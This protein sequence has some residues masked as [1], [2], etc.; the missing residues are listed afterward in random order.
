M[1]EGFSKVL[2]KTNDIHCTLNNRYNHFIIK[3]NL[4]KH[5]FNCW[6]SNNHYLPTS[7]YSFK[8]EF[9]WLSWW[10]KQGIY[11]LRLPL[12]WRWIQHLPFS[13]YHGYPPDLC[14]LSK[15]A[16]WPHYDTEYNKDSNR[17]EEPCLKSF[18]KIWTFLLFNP[19]LHSRK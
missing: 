3:S 18:E 17:D 5:D 11:F 1:L 19:Q 6:L 8:E 16:K 10:L 2:I 4:E 15:M 12:F 14:D 13:S 9:L 7:I